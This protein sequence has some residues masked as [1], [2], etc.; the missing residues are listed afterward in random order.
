MPYSLY[1]HLPF[2]RKK[3]HYCGFNSIT[4]GNDSIG[5]YAKAAS[6]EIYMRSHGIFD[7]KPGSVYIGGGTPSLVPVEAIKII[8]EKNMPVSGIECSI[9]ANPESVEDS[10]LKNILTLG[11]NRISIGIQ[12]LD[13]VLLNR[14]GRIHNASQARESVYKARHA[15]F[16]NISVDLIFGV[17]GQ[18][19]DMWTRTLRDVIDLKPDHISCYSLSIEEDSKYFEMIHNKKIQLPT[20]D[21]ISDMYIFMYDFLEMNGLKN[22]EI[23]N[24]ARPGYE[25]FHNI[26][27]WNFSPY[28]G[29]GLSAHSFDGTIRR[30][31]ESDIKRYIKTCFDSNDPVAGYEIPDQAEKTM[32]FIMLSLRT[33][34]GLSMNRLNKTYPSKCAEFDI[35]ITSLIASGFLEKRHGNIVRLTKNGIIIADEIITEVVSVFQ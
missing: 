16:N 13:D 14:L 28:L 2:C 32:E 1:I 31:N 12:S 3:C 27:Y 7:G 10:W 11:I 29:I 19:M 30:W 15:G 25:C 9:E 18:T 4:G 5:A 17:P 34:N 21:D 35:K 22:Y 23:S 26:S 33:K 6:C 8:L 24:F 20:S